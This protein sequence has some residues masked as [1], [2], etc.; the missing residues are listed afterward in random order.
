MFFTVNTEEVRMAA[1]LMGVK[2]DQGMANSF[3]EMQAA[4]KL[5]GVK[6]F[7]QYYRAFLLHLLEREF[8]ALTAH[9]NTAEDDDDLAAYAAYAEEEAD[10]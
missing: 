4:G 5:E 3:N 7:G 6:T 1:L 2:A 10:A 9:Q 8:A